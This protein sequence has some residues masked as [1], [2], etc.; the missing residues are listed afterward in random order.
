MRHPGGRTT[1]KFTSEI[2][3]HVAMPAMLLQPSIHCLPSLPNLS[4][5]S[6]SS[7]RNPAML[8]ADRSD[9]HGNVR[10]LMALLGEQW[11]CSATNRGPLS[12][13]SWPIIPLNHETLV[14][15]GRLQLYV[16]AT[17]T[18]D[19]IDYICRSMASHQPSPTHADRSSCIHMSYEPYY[20]C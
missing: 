13:T 7:C 4:K 8:Q 20:I 10:L 16:V 18:I 15:F 1:D 9:A 2:Y 12:V 17:S 11:P 19:S 6:K 3:L 5:L 14:Y